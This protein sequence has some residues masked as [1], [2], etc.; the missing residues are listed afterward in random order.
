MFWPYHTK[1]VSV[2]NNKNP[3]INYY[4]GQYCQKYSFWLPI[5]EKKSEKLLIRAKRIVNIMIG[6]TNET[7]TLM[8]IYN[9]IP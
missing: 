5:T 7:V 3:N 1:T 2:E 4:F 8:Y 9:E 6:H